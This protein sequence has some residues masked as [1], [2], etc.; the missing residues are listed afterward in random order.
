MR[1]LRAQPK[2]Q[3]IKTKPNQSQR[4]L[5]NK[6]FSNCNMFAFPFDSVISWINT[7]LSFSRPKITRSI[8]DTLPV[9]CHLLFVIQLIGMRA[10]T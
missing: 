2:E 10:V 9:M 8:C 1:V 6:T 7:V 3:W 4:I 5:D